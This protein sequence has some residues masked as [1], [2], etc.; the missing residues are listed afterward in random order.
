MPGKGAF[1]HY[2]QATGTVLPPLNPSGRTRALT[3]D[4]AAMCTLSFL[5]VPRQRVDWL[6]FLDLLVVLIHICINQRPGVT[7][8]ILMWKV[9]AGGGG[10]DV[11]ECAQ[12]T[13]WL[14]RGSSAC[15]RSGG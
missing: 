6:P 13:F 4:S 10:C 12:S 2:G 1:E 15:L 11:C 7:N 3:S 8:P 9:M 14:A 5:A